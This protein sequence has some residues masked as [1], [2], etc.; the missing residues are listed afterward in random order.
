MEARSV[1]ELRKETL[2]T[3]QGLFKAEKSN[4]FLTNGDI[5]HPGLDLGKVITNGVSE[6][7]FRLF[8]RY[9]HQLDPFKNM[10][11]KQARLPEVL[12]FDQIMPFRKLIKTEYYNDFLKPQ[13]IHDQL[14]IYLRSGD[15]LVGVAALFRPKNFPTFSSDD[16]AKAKIMVPFLNAAMERAISLKK[17]K[18]LETA[19]CAVTPDLPYEGMLILDQS[20]T[21]GYYDDGADTILNRLHRSDRQHSAFPEDLPEEL[22]HA[23]KQLSSEI[24]SQDPKEIPCT[25]ITFSAGN[26]AK[27]LKAQLR[28]L[29]NDKNP[30]QILVC[31]NP[32]NKPMKSDATLIK[33]GISKRELDIIHL[34]TQGKKNSEIASALFISNYTVENHLRSIY[35]KMDVKNRTALVFKLMKTQA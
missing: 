8:R 15:C 4:F 20:L 13:N 21:V 5:R 11:Q 10:I 22:Q 14:T 26:D 6:K 3:L 30:P 27:P 33:M 35:K 24:E 9:Y 29:L 19:I 2:T 16:K 25:E 12:T 28:V 34:I 17:S 32:T 1:E 7:N 31:F 23:A 18:E